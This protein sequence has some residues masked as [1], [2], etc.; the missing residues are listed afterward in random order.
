MK[1]LK[2]YRFLKKIYVNDFFHKNL[3]LKGINVGSGR[4]WK[5]FR[6]IGIDRLNGEKLDEKSIFPFKMNQSIMF[7]QVTLLNM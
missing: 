1:Y 3:R 5:E 4:N 2:K 6:F 7:I